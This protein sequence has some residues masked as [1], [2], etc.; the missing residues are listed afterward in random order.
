[1]D[2]TMDHG[3]DDH[4]GG[5]SPK[6]NHHHIDSPITYEKLSSET[7]AQVDVVIKWAKKYKTGADAAK[8]GWTQATKSLYGIGAHWLKGGA[9]GFTKMAKGVD[10][11]AP[12]VLLFDGEGPTAKLAGVSWIIGSNTDPEGF[13]GPDDHWH[14]HSSVCFQTSTLL[15]ISEG[16]AKGSPINLS[17]EGCKRNKGILF[18]ISNLTMMHLWIGDGYM[19][20][21]PLFAHNHPLLLNGYRPNEHPSA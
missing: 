2:P 14:R 17:A 12:N 16:D 11:T 18:P 20:K 6:V 21:G 1:M 7:K 8:D 10:I 4:A 9:V 5:G 3:G 19:G 15:V 13:V